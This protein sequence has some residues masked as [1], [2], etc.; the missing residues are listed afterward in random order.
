MKII[1]AYDIGDHRNRERFARFLM[2]KG[3][4]RI[5]KSL[6]IG[7]GS[8]QKIKDIV[9]YAS[10][11]IDPSNDCVHVFMLGDN[12]YLQAKIIGKPWSSGGGD[13]VQI[14]TII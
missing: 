5:Q 12:E 2:R 3:L 8:G 13:I 6:F 11:I 9:R 10:K 7:R 1:V 4:E 14:A